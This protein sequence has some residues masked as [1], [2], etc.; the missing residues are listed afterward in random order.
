MWHCYVN[1]QVFQS[2]E[3]LIIDHPCLSL[4]CLYLWLACLHAYRLEGKLQIKAVF[5]PATHHHLRMGACI[6]GWWCCAR[7]NSSFIRSSSSS[8]NACKGYLHAIFVSCRSCALRWQ[9]LLNFFWNHWVM[10]VISA[11]RPCWSFLCSSLNRCNR[12]NLKLRGE[13]CWKKA[14]KEWKWSDSFCKEPA[15][16]ES[17]LGTFQP[18][19]AETQKQLLGGICQD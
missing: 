16:H 7:A 6:R 14:M 8:P 2:L 10:R 19:V 13:V 5:A 12:M 3:V 18:K 17:N 15:R 4:W 11:Q 1:H 9:M